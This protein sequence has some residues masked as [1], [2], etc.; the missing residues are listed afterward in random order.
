MYLALGLNGRRFYGLLNI[1]YATSVASDR[2]IPNEL[3]KPTTQT[4]FAVNGMEIALLG[5]VEFTG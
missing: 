1:G 2:V 5:E 3:L 4:L